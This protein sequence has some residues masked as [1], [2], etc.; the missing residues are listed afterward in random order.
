MMKFL[1][2]DSK[3]TLH[4]TLSLFS[5]EQDIELFLATYNLA[6]DYMLRNEEEAQKYRSY[7]L[8]FGL[9]AEFEENE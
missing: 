7:A 2:Q 8:A 3:K 4:L 6:K 9:V 5:G 1:I